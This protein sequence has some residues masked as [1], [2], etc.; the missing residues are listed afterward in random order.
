VRNADRA[1]LGAPAAGIRSVPPHRERRRL[2]CILRGPAAETGAGEGRPRGQRQATAPSWERRRPACIQ[3]VPPH[4]ERRRPA[5]ILRG[6]A[7]E[8]GAG[9]GRPRGQRQATA[10]SWERRR[11]ACIRGVPPHRER[12]RPACILRGPAALPRRATDYRVRTTD[13][14]YFLATSATRRA[15][16]RKLPY[17]R[18]R[19]TLNPTDRSHRATSTPL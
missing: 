12:R 15:G 3:G 13:Q 9:E 8:T 11:P 17:P 18:S 2:A 7:A 4:R 1:V 19:R 10:P 5:C 6:R 14:L 16:N